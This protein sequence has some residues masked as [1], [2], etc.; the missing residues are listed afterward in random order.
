M[1]GG[2]G[3]AHLAGVVDTDVI[4][5]GRLADALARA[6]FDGG[7]RRTNFVVGQKVILVMVGYPVHTE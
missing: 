4:A 3:A 1:A 2:A 5:Q 7:P 6:R